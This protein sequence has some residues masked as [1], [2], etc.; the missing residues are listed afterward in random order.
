MDM[1][2]D[3]ANITSIVTFVIDN[4]VTIAVLFMSWPLILIPGLAVA[5]IVFA[6]AKGIVKLRK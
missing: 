4:V 3:L 5:G 6:K 2:T 1:V